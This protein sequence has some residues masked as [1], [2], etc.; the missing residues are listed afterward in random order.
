[1]ILRSLWFSFSSVFALFCACAVSSLNSIAI[2]YRSQ[3]SLSVLRCFLEVLRVR[4][5]FVKGWNVFS[6]HFS[7]LGLHC[8][9]LQGSLA[10]RLSTD[11]LSPE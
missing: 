5:G 6:K 1:M 2:L 3:V 8:S 11:K 7:E 10:G 9:S 4:V